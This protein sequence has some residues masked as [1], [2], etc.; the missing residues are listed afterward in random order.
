MSSLN[1]GATKLVDLASSNSLLSLE[2]LRIRLLWLQ[3][4]V[5]GCG[6]GVFKQD[7]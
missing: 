1:I 2:V 4:V 3:G 5:V 7:S 6:A